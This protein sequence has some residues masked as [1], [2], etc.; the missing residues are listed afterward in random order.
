M[1]PTSGGRRTIPATFLP[2]L[3]LIAC[4]AAAPVA[5][6]EVPTFRKGMWEYDTSVLLNGKQFHST[7]SQCGDPTD[8]VKA[9]LA[10]S[11]PKGCKVDGPN[12]LGNTYTISAICPEGRSDVVL[13]V[14]GDAG[15][16]EVIESKMG[17]TSSKQTL[18]AHRTGDCQ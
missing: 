13:T 10:P 2:A 7:E 5:A 1:Q 4:F 17:E 14:D 8:S 3:L 18:T 16:M 11:L 6:D 9:L 15:F 12:R